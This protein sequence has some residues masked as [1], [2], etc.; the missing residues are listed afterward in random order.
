MRDLA[1]RRPRGYPAGLKRV[2]WVG[3]S[4]ADLK[5]FPATAMDDMGH[6]KLPRSVDTSS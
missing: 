2:V 3:S 5:A 4:K 1:W 6:R